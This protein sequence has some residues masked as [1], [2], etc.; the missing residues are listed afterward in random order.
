MLEPLLY[1][2]VE[3]L[4]AEQPLV[5]LIPLYAIPG[6]PRAIGRNL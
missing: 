5:R 3:C 1:P 2:A 6:S 4:L